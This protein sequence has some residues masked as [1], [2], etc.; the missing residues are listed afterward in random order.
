MDQY[1]TKKGNMC[2]QW[3]RDKYSVVITRHTLVHL[4]QNSADRVND[5]LVYGQCVHVLQFI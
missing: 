4:F 3:T 2:I 1:I 5:S